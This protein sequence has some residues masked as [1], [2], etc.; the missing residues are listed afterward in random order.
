M[1]K[2]IEAKF[3][4]I[5]KDDIIL[6]LKQLGAEMSMRKD[7]YEEGSMICPTPRLVP[8]PE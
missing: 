7:Y 6:K 4:N 1:A 3:I 2:E 8:G 5:N